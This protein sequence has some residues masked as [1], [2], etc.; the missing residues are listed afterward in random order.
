LQLFGLALLC[1]CTVITRYCDQEGIEV[2]APQS[3]S[4]LA[5]IYSFCVLGLMVMPHQIYGSSRGSLALTSGISDH[6]P[7][8]GICA[9]LVTIHGYK[10]QEHEVR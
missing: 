10:C 5:S 7:A 1:S 6:P 4:R 2:M 9:T 8:D 3:M